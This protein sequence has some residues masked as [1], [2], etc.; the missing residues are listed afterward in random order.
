MYYLAQAG[1]NLKAITTAGVLAGLTLPSGITVSATVRGRF[2][3]FNQQIFFVRAG[4]VNLWID[5]YDNTVRPMN[6]QPPL[7]PPDLA[8]GSGSGLSGKYRGQVA[9][10]VKNPAGEV[11]NLSPLSPLSLQTSTLANKDLSWTNIPISPDA[12]QFVSA[13]SDYVF[14]RRLFRTAAGGTDTFEL[15]DIDDNITTTILDTMPDAS[16]S[17]LPASPD[18]GVPP[19]ARPGTALG[20]LVEWKNRLW[21]VSTRADELDLVLFT[22]IDEFYAWNPD[23]VLKARPIGADAFGVTGFLPRRDFLGIGKRDRL[24]KV[25]GSTPDDFEVVEVSAHV[26]CVAPESCVVIRDVAY[27]LGLDGVY[28]WDDS[29]VVNISRATVDSWFTKD[30]V[31]NRS[32][33]P[34]AFAGWN[35]TT[36]A[37]ELHLAA[38][39]S[40]NEDRWIAYHIDAG[41]WLGPHKTD[42]FTPTCAGLLQASTDAFTPAI[43][44]S[45]GF[46]YL[47]N[48]ATPS[49]VPGGSSAVAIDAFAQAKFHQGE[50]DAPAPDIMHYFGRLILLTRK[51]SSGTMTVTPYLATRVDNPT[52]GAAITHDLTTGGET[53]RRIG[54]SNLCSLKFAQ[55]SAGKRFLIYAYDFDRVYEVGR[56]T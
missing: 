25:I 1:A 46:I 26:S 32:R 55:A 56:R 7:S 12:S 53:L 28:R 19:G 16:L 20:L 44:G 36:N 41:E 15:I 6:I 30:V 52:A 3:I 27:F 9:Y 10:F 5:P 39:G 43:G 14:G 34:N 49:D 31:F 17:L 4:T 42:A 40:S 2:A 18:L 38:A 21:G 29:G 22:E 51:E 54:V 33:F 45:D 8:A 47:Q 48:Q 37:Y 24:L 23:N 13:T 35:P 11:V 50:I